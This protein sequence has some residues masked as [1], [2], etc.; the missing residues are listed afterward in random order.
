M[1]PRTRF[2]EGASGALPLGQCP[3][4]SPNLGRNGPRSES[5]PRQSLAN[6]F[7]FVDNPPAAHV[8]VRETTLSPVDPESY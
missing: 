7:R 5:L 4:I 8:S 6:D 3:F 1:L 2:I